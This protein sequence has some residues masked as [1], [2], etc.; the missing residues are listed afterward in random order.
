MS[1]TSLRHRIAIVFVG[2]L[3]LVM[4]LVLALVHSSSARI[5]E[6]ETQ[7]ELAV[8]AKV[9][10]RLLEQNQRQLETAAGVLSADFAFREAIATQ[11]QPTVRSVIRNHGQRIHAQVMMVTGTDGRMI[12]AT[13]STFAAGDP[14]PFP[15]LLAAAEA[16]GRSAGFRQMRNG[17]LFQVVLVPIMAPTR[18]AWVAMG[19]HVDDRWAHEMAGVTGLG[20]HIVR[21]GMPGLLA[22][23]GAAATDAGDARN[24][25]VGVPLDGGLQ[26]V[27]QLP[28]AQVQA[29][30][31]QL[32]GRLLGVIAA[33]VLVFA[34]GSVML[35]G[36]IVRPLNDL[37][38]A[39][40]RIALGDYAQPLPPAQ[41]DEIGQLAGSFEQM[42]TGIASREERIVRLAYVDELTDLP[43]RTRFLEAFGRLTPGGGGAVIVVNIDR[44]ALINN[45]L[46]HLVG[47]RLLRAVAGQLR[48]L[49]PAGGM[50]A[51]LWGDQFAFLLEGADLDAARRFADGVLAALRDPV[52]LDGQRLDIEAGLGIALYPDDGLDAAT[53]LRR[54][55]LALA[56]AKRRHA[57]VAFASETGAEP[58]HEQLSL[59]GDMR[60]ALLAGEFTLAYQPKLALA[61]GRIV[62]VEAL[63][64]WQHP[65]R[66]SIAPARFIPFAEQTGFIREITPWVLETAVRQAA[67]WHAAGLDI[68][69]SANLS[70]LDLLDPHLG[71]RVRN[72]LETHA[73]P[74]RRLCLEITESALMDDPAQA[75]AHLDELAALG[76]KLS[77][78]DYGVGQA[79][80]AYLKSLPVDELKL[81]RSFITA[82]TESPRNAAIVESTIMLSHALGL[83]VV[84]EGVET[85]AELRWLREHGC[86]IAQ[87][88]GI[89]RPMAA[90]QL[91]GWLA[92]FAARTTA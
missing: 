90:T 14:F 44:F 70:T 91:Q 55:E 54:A 16:A 62:A 84:A 61:G 45:A 9:F 35:A 21:V 66:G 4:G 92:D 39:A 23:S 7:R 31:N 40:R 65:E 81:D 56:A 79:S 64:R 27:L 24:A 78:D 80:L 82:I 8:G 51:R 22:S 89:A 63:L 43:N 36:R 68:A 37:S 73:V 41:G 12:A 33:A 85:Q 17:Q 34:L 28:V 87:G 1:S 6:R 26:A 5:V 53:L 67:V 48:P 29:P 30:F 60:R 38:A 76:I 72:L 74:A 57:G 88:Y 19:F 46:G 52:T 11:D 42:R 77:I 2:L 71:R 50:L 25:S 47:D 32:Q 15:D 20:V 3:V 49:A 58:A 75:Q 10:Q 86:D 18:I 69:V 59:I 83:T 13:Q